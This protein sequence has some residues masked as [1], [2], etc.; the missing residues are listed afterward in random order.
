MIRR[1]TLAALAL[2]AASLASLTA[3]TA[4]AHAT[5]ISLAGDG[6]W[7]S[8]TVDNLVGPTFGTRWIDFV[9]GSALSFNFTIGAGQLGTLTVVDS[10]FAGDTFGVSN[11]GKLLGLTSAVA[12]G[13]TEGPLAL[14]FDDALA[15]K[16]F[17]RG[18]FTL[19]EGTYSIGGF[20]SQS[21]TDNGVPLF[22]TEGGLNLTVAPVPE[23][24]TYAFLLAGLGMTLLRARRNRSGR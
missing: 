4:P 20:L 21:V 11:F 12:V 15:D 1:P 3:W 18:V 23:P 6:Q 7:N 17:S 24:A 14:G 9:D 19:G 16:S 13:T 5:A 22:A 8:F 2:A 10:G